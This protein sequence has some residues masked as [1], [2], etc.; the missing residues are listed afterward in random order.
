M[1]ILPCATRC[2]LSGR[3]FTAF[4]A[5]ALWLNSAT[6]WAE[7]AAERTVPFTL[8][9]ARIVAGQ[10]IENGDGKL[11]VL[12]AR[13]LLKADPQDPY[14][15]F[16]LARGLEMQ[17][18][19]GAGRRAAG[20]A[21]RAS[22][23]DADRFIAAQMAARM[24]YA[25]RR[26]GL[27]QYWLRR[28]LD[29]A[30][31]EALKEQA[32]AD[33]RRV[34]REN[35]WNT[36]YRI[37][38]Q[39][40]D[41]INSGT[42]NPYFLV[43]GLPW[44]GV[45]SAEAMALSGTEIRLEARSSYRLRE[46]KLSATRLTGE[47]STRRVRLSQ[48]AKAAAPDADGDDFSS[49]RAEFGVDHRWAVGGDAG[50]NGVAGVTA[51]LG[52]VWYGGE[53]SYTYGNVGLS[54]S[55]ALGENSLLSVRAEYERRED[56]TAYFARSDHMQLRGDFR[57]RL[58]QAAALSM[59]LI[60]DRADS[61]RGNVDVLHRTA[62]VS[63]DFGDVTGPVDLRLTLGARNTD[64]PRYFIGFFEAPGGRQDDAV[65]ASLDITFSEIDYAGFVPRVTL[66]TQSTTSNIS[67]FETRSTAL[68]FGIESKF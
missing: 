63:Y 54:H 32:V 45:H 68:S 18:H 27:A 46:D 65:F 67:R 26:Y 5:C 6:A 21:F 50:A 42:D 33:F 48:E 38:V 58:P 57:H 55:F 19:H 11:A 60:L 14:A 66:L 13:G 59:G 25:D 47:L 31:T 34:R 41:N 37:T 28:S 22:E 39:P 9:Q 10:A 62:Y 12:L 35:P 51:A 36:R 3:K 1:R 30:P 43:D 61:D 16:I 8:P 17:K 44:Y 52:Q 24:A 4:F 15:L 20:R 29:P 40:S 2:A 53:T 49:T 23:K 56:A 64:Y 7:T